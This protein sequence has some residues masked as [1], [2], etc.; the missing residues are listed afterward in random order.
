MNNRA[1]RPRGMIGFA[2]ASAAVAAALALYTP[3]LGASRAKVITNPW[4]SLT[5]ERKQAVVDQTHRANIAYLQAF[6]AR[7]GDPR[8]LPVIRISTW[9][10]PPPSVGT[11]IKQ[12]SYLVHGSV[13]SVHF[14]PDPS[15]NLPMTTAT[16]TVKDVGRGAMVA[17]TVVVRQVGGPVAQP[18]G[19]GAL[20]ML[21]TDELLM[22][23]DDVL[24]L[25]SPDGD[26]SLKPVSG[27]GVYFVRSGLVQG[28]AASRYGLNG[29][30]FAEIWKVL[31]DPALSAS[32]FPLKAIPPE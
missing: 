24:L 12:A 11:A 27:A 5:D 18:G 26:G 2:L 30:P 15:G 1:S 14:T 3:A 13:G 4:A 9:Q 10:G 22:P 31:S 16:V 28:Q 19:R 29:R 6:E 25:L 32:A 17:S 20:V 8:S 7:H 21:D 23:G